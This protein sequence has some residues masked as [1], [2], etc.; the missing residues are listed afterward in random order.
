MNLT[1]KSVNL[2]KKNRA[3]HKHDREVIKMVD[4]VTNQSVVDELKHLGHDYHDNITIIIIIIILTGTSNELSEHG[5]QTFPIWLPIAFS[6]PP[7]LEVRRQ[8]QLQG[9]HT[10]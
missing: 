5:Y 2:E 9:G 1:T 6:L 4:C 8:S 7:L 3:I 10:T